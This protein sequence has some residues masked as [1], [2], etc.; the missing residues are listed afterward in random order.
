MDLNKITE[1]ISGTDSITITHVDT[2]NFQSDD[3]NV[4]YNYETNFD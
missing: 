4:F 2:N 1:I 3:E